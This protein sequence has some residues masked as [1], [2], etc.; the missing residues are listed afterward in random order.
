MKTITQR[1]PF[2]LTTATPVQG[3][4]PRGWLAV[5]LSAAL[6]CCSC[7][8]LT[9]DRIAVLAALAGNAAQI[10]V[11]EWLRQ[12]P[13]HRESFAAVARAI[14]A[15]LAAQGG[16]AEERES[17]VVELLSSMPTRTLASK[18]GGLYLTGTPGTNQPQRGEL[19]VWDETLKKASV[20]E[21]AAT[22]PVLKAVRDGMR[23]ALAVKAP[24]PT[25]PRFLYMGWTNDPAFAVVSPPPLPRAV[26]GV[27]ALRAQPR[28][29]PHPERTNRGTL[30]QQAIP[31]L[32][33]TNT[34]R[35]IQLDYWDEPVRPEPTPKPVL[36]HTPVVESPTP[37][38]QAPK[39]APQRRVGIYT[40]ERRNGTNW[41]EVQSFTSGPAE[42]RVRRVR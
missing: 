13:T 8:T 21:G 5:I 20:I 4:H 14:A 2:F 22:E 40:V 31:Y 34:L 23:R 12:H 37:A 6:L 24:M 3:C 11:E 17:K 19:V 35:V 36:V 30:W 32:D 42:F 33:R 7:S 39:H 16:S 29:D 28:P 18:E 41:V 10:G 25:P 1:R 27:E 38:V 26:T 15:F 9:P